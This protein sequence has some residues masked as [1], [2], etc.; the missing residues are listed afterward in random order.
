MITPLFSERLILYSLK[1][2][3]VLFLRQRVV[4]EDKGQGRFIARDLTLEEV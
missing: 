4:G 1:L 2:A 3:R